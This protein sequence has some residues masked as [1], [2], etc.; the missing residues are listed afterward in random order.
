MDLQFAIQVIV[1]ALATVGIEEF[2]KNFFKPKNKK[3]YAILMLPLSVFCFCAASLLP[4][5][6]IGS[7]L[8]IGCVQLCYQTLVQGFKIILENAFERMKGGGNKT[9]ENTSEKQE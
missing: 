3:W 6:I 7:L 9:V 5:Y 1:A 8:T 4:L 2:F